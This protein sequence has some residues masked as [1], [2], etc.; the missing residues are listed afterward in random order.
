MKKIL[1]ISPYVPYD[2]V[3]HAG[4]QTENYYVKGLKKYGFNI[5]VL[6][7]C[8]EDEIKKI[9]LNLYK[10]NN[11]IILLKRDLM[12][13]IIRAFK[14]NIIDSKYNPFNKYGNLVSNNFIHEVLKHCQLY[15]S[16]GYKPDVTVLEWTESALLTAEIKKIYPRTKILCIEEDV[17]YLGYKRHMEYAKGL[18]NKLI[19]KIRYENL[20]KEE[21]CALKKAEYIGC[22]NEKDCKLLCSDGIESQ[23][24][25]KWV[26]FFKQYDYINRRPSQKCKILFFG[27]M[28][29]EENYASAIWFVENVV[30]LLKDIDFEFNVVGAKPARVLNRYES[31]KVHI[32]GFVKDIKP[33]FEESL[34]LVAPLVLGAGIKIKILE[35]LSAGIPV[36]TNDIGIE[37]IPAENGKDYIYCCEPEEYAR[38]IEV[39][40][41]NR[42]LVEMYSTNAKI[43]IKKQ[44]NLNESLK[45]LCEIIEKT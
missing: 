42:S 1:W 11:D 13:K 5:R 27:N 45:D 44:Y 24:V 14:Y 22:L 43:F 10:I 29:R 25:F 30:P 8:T 32:I 16:K 20:K 37:G 19:W 38:Q 41:I 17:A 23:N 6:S 35:S 18:V 34:C 28:A 36:L 31:E 15:E 40:N 39:L 12:S 3:D 26:P 7:F 9:D 4:G 33:Y 2:G 21:L